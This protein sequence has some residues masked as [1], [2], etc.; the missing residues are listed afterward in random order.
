MNL[1]APLYGAHEDDP[2]R[3]FIALTRVLAD[4]AG[5]DG[6]SVGEIVDR[7]D[8]R[9]S[10]LLIL[11]LTLPCL[12]PAL[13]GVQVLAI[14]IFLLAAQILVGRAEPWLPGWLLR[15]RA[16]REWLTAIA[17]F[18]ENRL[19]WTERI[20]R[21]RLT[22]LAAGPGERLAALAMALAAITVMLPIT[23]TVPSVGLLF[24][25][26]GVLQR[27]G[28]FVAAGCLV[29]VAWFAFLVSLA[30]A[31]FFGAGFILDFARETAPWLLPDG[32][33]E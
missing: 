17:D 11:V 10:A 1:R 25:C 31:V 32:L 7:L 22:A 8:E 3:G 18:A 14:G 6:L 24:L 2:R 4:G 21:P 13:P 23:N 33:R 26:V 12:V 20:S 5:P 15:L 27:D 9:A 30:A 19:A 29:V 16:R 28:V